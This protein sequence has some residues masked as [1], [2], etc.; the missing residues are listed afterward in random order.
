M[1][2][3]VVRAR[4]ARDRIERKLKRVMDVVGA[5][6][7]LVFLAIPLALVAILIRVTEGSPVLFKQV[8]P[9]LHGRPFELVK[10]RTMRD[11]LDA[12][13]ESLSEPERI[14]GLGDF[15]RRTS[16][17]ELPEL[18]N[19]LKGDMSLVGPRP[20]LTEYLPLYTAEENRRHDVRPGLTG[21]AQ[22][23]GRRLLDMPDRFVLDVW[24]VDNWSLSLDLRI[25]AMTARKVLTGEGVTPVKPDDLSDRDW[26]T[27]DDVKAAPDE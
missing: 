17:D 19:I 18:W 1:D 4:P 27:I 10:F 20:L 11:G 23:H 2:R 25:L 7:G 16:L 9:G 3:R 13:D 8:R 15:L 21:L 24:Y 14:T 6:V 22:V 12:G 26:R 5:S